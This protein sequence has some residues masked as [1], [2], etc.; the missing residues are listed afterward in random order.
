MTFA[1]LGD[2]GALAGD[3]VLAGL[4]NDGVGAGLV[5]EVALLGLLTLDYPV[6][7]ERL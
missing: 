4:G 3:G 7:V 1:E 2:D 5:L 6:G